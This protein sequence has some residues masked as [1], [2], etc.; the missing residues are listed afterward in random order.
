MKKLLLLSLLVSSQLTFSQE[1]LNLNILGEELKDIAKIL[2]QDFKI[3][4]NKSLNENFDTTGNLAPFTEEIIRNAGM[5]TG[6][7]AVVFTTGAVFGPKLATAISLKIIA[8]FAT[9]TTFKASLLPI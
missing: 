3:N 9:K 1:E 4:W 8:K 6:A 5:Q 2:D 7:S